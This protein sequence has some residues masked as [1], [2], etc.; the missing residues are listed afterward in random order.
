MEATGKQQRERN[1]EK[2]YEAVLRAAEILFARKGFAGTSMSQI[3]DSAGV[4]QPLIHHHFGGKEQLYTE[5]KGHVMKRIFEAWEN[6]SDSEDPMDSL[7]TRLRTVCQLIGEHPTFMRLVQWT[8][9]EDGDDFWPGEER[10]VAS[11]QRQ[12]LQGQEDG[13]IRRDIDAMVI[14]VMSQAL[15]LYWWEDRRFLV[16]HFASQKNVDEHYLQQ[17]VKVF[18]SGISNKNNQVHENEKLQTVCA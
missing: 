14:A 11:L 9:M 8:R 5:V 12:I 17:M 4:S 16:K 13:I 18:L 2:T 15:I 1:A 10:L 3:A 6:A 7:E